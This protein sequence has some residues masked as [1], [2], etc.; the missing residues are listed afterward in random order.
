MRDDGPGGGGPR[1]WA[2]FLALGALAVA[3][4]LAL[5]GPH[6]SEAHPHSQFATIEVGGG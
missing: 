5:P 6:R 4:G 3:I 1:L 2:V